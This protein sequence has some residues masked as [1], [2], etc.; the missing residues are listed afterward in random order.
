MTKRSCI[1]F[2]LFAIIGVNG[3][4]K[5][6]S[7]SDNVKGPVEIRLEGTENEYKAPMLKIHL[8]RKG[9]Y[10]GYVNVRIPETV[11]GLDTKQNKFLRFFQDLRSPEWPAVLQAEPVSLP[12]PWVGG[13]KNLSYTLRLDNGMFFETTVKVEG[14]AVIFS[15]TLHNN[16]DHDLK[17]VGMRTCPALMF[18]PQLNDTFM[19]RTAIKI[20][21]QFKRFIDIIPSSTNYTKEKAEYHRFSANTKGV[22]DAAANNPRVTPHPGFLDDPNRNIY[23]W[24]IE[25]PVDQAVI[26][27]VSKDNTWG[28]MT[29]SNPDT[30]PVWMN[31]ALC[32]QHS[33]PEVASCPPGDT[34]VIKLKMLFFDGGLEDL[35]SIFSKNFNN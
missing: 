35:N 17:R 23:G 2:C 9:Q 20:D 33:D 22:R 10:A 13:E 29:Y 8:T 26:A 14:S 7:N 32:C 3:C 30:Q 21:G 27:T 15:Y 31:P 4:K 6:Q 24:F 19:E 1:L 28:V 11:A 25:K 34:A 5:S 12:V 18:V 16:T